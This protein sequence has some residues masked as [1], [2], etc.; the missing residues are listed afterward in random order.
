MKNY[1]LHKA[2]NEFYRDFTKKVMNDLEK[3]EWAK[4]LF[5]IPDV[6]VVDINDRYKALETMFKIKE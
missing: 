3:I 1:I 5:A 2:L 4:K 6:N